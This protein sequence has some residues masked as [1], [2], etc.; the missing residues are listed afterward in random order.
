M[1]QCLEC[2]NCDTL[3]IAY[4]NVFVSGKCPHCD[5]ATIAP[6]DFYMEPEQEVDC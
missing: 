6:E 3:N 5:E 1:Y 4:N 2:E